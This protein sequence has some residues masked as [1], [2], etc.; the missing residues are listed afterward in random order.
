MPPLTQ[1]HHGQHH[2]RIQ[3]KLLLHQSRLQSHRHGEKEK[4]T[5]KVMVSRRHGEKEKAT[6]KVVVHLHTEVA[7]GTI[8]DDIKGTENGDNFF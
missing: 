8:R 1:D 3:A 6:G 4:A 7:T 5:G 2:Q